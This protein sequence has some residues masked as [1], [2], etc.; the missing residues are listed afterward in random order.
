MTKALLNSIAEAA[1]SILSNT[2]LLSNGEVD[3]ILCLEEL[4]AMDT[5]L[6]HLVEITQ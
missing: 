3:D 6:W 5:R 4:E 2:E 1:T